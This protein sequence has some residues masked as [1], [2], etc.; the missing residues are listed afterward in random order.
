M[1]VL[2]FAQ[3]ERFIHEPRNLPGPSIDRDG[4]T[5]SFKLEYYLTVGG[6]E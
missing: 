3:S 6:R 4:D 1:F 5:P 2:I